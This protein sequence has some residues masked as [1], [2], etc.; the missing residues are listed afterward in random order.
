MHSKAYQFIPSLSVSHIE[1]EL[2][3]CQLKRPSRFSSS[4]LPMPGESCLLVLLRTPPGSLRTSLIPSSQWVTTRSVNSSALITTIVP[5]RPGPQM[6]I[7]TQSFSVFFSV[8]LTTKPAVTIALVVPTVV[9]VVQ[10]PHARPRRTMSI[11]SSVA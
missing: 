2:Q 3:G 1:A 5:S 4:W 6:R 10:S 11:I 8:K 9:L 7:S